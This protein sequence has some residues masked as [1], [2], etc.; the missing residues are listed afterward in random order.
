[1]RRYSILC[2][3]RRNKSRH[4]LPKQ[5]SEIFA[6]YAQF[7]K[8]LLQSYEVLQPTLVIARSISMLIYKN[9]GDLLNNG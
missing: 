8:T 5:V 2:E 3:I 7:G 4:N 9:Y 1:M 6:D